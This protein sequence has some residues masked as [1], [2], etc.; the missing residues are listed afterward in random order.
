MSMKLL[1]SLILSIA[2]L[3]PLSVQA[4]SNY[5]QVNCEAEVLRV[6][7]AERNVCLEMNSNLGS[8]LA[9]LSNCAIRASRKYIANSCFP[10]LK[11]AVNYYS[12]IWQQMKIINEQFARKEISYDTTG[13]QS[14]ML[15][16]LTR[17]WQSEYDNTVQ[18]VVRAVRADEAQQ[19]S[20]QYLNLAFSGL[21]IITKNQRGYT[22]ENMTYILNGKTYVC[23]TVGNVTNCN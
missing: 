23:T 17:D 2:F 20:R 13:R 16:N 19:Q 4:Q 22:P 6:F 7:N 21:N 8:G 18:N 9:E 12:M 3:L 10:S 14:L 1:N 5:D 15:I 11:A